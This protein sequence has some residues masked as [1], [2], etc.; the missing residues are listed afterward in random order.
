MKKKTIFTTMAIL[1][2]LGASSFLVLTLRESKIELNPYQALGTVA[3]EQTIKLMGDKGQIVIVAQDTSEFDMPAL[4]AQLNAFRATARAKAKVT[5]EIENVKMDAMTMLAAGGRVPAERFLKTLRKYP[6]AGA[7]VLF[8]GF[9]QLA[10]RDLDA[11]HQRVP[12][13]IV[14]AAYRP[15]YQELLERRLIDLAIVPR[16]DALPET[17]KKPKTLREWFEQEYVI[18]APDTAAAL[19]R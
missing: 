16:L 7:I 12:K 10:G 4:A 17:A 11:L 6:K 14:V 19:P 3:A 18:L 8:L 9:P 2:T 5:V 1:G 15:D 13:M